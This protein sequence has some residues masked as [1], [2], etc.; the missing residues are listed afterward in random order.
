MD[1]PQRIRYLR[2]Q[3]QLTQQQLARELNISRATLCHYENGQREPD[4][5][6]LNAI[7]DF[8]GVSLDY[9]VCRTNLDLFKLTVLLESIFSTEDLEN[10]ISAFT[11]ANLSKG[12]GAKPWV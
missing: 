8:F 4:L 9:L 3:R 2:L 12:K 10:M 5:Q 6:T 7:A 1:L 11:T